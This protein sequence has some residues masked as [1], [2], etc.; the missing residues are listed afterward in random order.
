MH[1]Q[2]HVFTHFFVFVTGRKTNNGTKLPHIP[3]PFTA[4]RVQLEE[5]KVVDVEE[6]V[7]D[8][9]VEVSIF[10]CVSVKIGQNRTFLYFSARIGQKSAIHIFNVVSGRQV[11]AAQAKKWKDARESTTW[12]TLNPQWAK[13]FK[14]GHLALWQIRYFQSTQA[15][16]LSIRKLPFARLVKEIAQDFKMDLWFTA[17]SILALHHACKYFLV[18]V[19]QLA[20]IHCRWVTIAPKDMYLVQALTNMW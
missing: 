1:V 7:V 19:M 9:D 4:R 17:T 3:I 12:P 6:E 2:E 15:S 18:E 10:V 5:V 8:V 11:S 14:S 13:S 16:M 20:A